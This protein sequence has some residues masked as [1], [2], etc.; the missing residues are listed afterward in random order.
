M[1]KISRNDPCWCGSGAKYKKCHMNSDLES[2]NKPD[3]KNGQESFIGKTANGIIIKTPKQVDG[4]RISSQIT[5][6]TLDMI[7]NHIKAGISTD[8]INSIVHDYIIQRGA[9][10]APLNYHGFPKS[11]CTSLNNVICHGIPDKTILKDGDIINIDV[12]TIYNGYF[13]DASRMY[14]IGEISDNVRKLVDV[15]KECLNIALTRV[16][17]YAD[18]SEIGLVIEEHAKKNGFSVVKDYGGHG[19]GLSF[20][21]E[22]HIHHYSKKKSGIKMLPGMTFTIEPM[23]NSGKYRSKVLNDDWTAVTADNSL[24]SQWEHTILVTETGYEILT[25]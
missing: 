21:E 5:K 11:V 19:I 18:F 23:I 14:I 25:A 24:S 12:T 15:S 4:I 20:H 3:K 22:P 2:D 6:D 1:S 8:E 10:P 7:G 9:I 17:P 13:G 16:K